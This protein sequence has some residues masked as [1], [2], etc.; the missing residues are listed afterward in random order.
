[1]AT[2]DENDDAADPFST[3]LPTNATAEQIE[4]HRVELEAQKKKEVE[5]RKKFHLKQSAVA[6]VLRYCTT[7]ITQRLQ[8]G[9]TTRVLDF[10]PDADPQRETDLEQRHNAALGSSRPP[11]GPE[12]PRI[13]GPE[14]PRQA[15]PPNR[16]VDP[17][18]NLLL[19]STP[20]DNIVAAQAAVDQLAATGTDALQI[21]YVKAL[22]TKAVEQQQAQCDSQG[23]MYTRST[24]SR[25]ASSAARHA[26][27]VAN[28]GPDPRQCQVIP[29]HSTT[30][31]PRPQHQLV[32]AN[33]QPIDACT[34]LNNVQQW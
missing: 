31:Q 19:F 15:T 20:M 27:T 24:A 33:G 5:E 3:P 9:T 16:E 21:N 11:G 17:I 26:I 12:Q 8:A 13:T 25:A 30:N 7:R 29:T 34:H 18:T 1:M 22:V 2:R 6:N 4:Q 32:A 14:Q 10:G 23:R 28:N